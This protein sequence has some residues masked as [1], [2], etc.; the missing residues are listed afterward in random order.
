MIKKMY[1]YIKKKTELNNQHLTGLILKF[2]SLLNLCYPILMYDILSYVSDL[3]RDR[4]LTAHQS[5][6]YGDIMVSLAGKK[7]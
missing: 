4:K 6:A 2:I 5:E 7:A 3:C 1:L